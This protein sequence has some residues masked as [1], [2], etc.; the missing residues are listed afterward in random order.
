MLLIKKN[1]FIS[2][3]GQEI[4]HRLVSPPAAES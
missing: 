3:K 1:N 4:M 2:N